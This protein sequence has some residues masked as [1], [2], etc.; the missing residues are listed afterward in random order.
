MV[1]EGVIVWVLGEKVV[2]DV[3]DG[4]T[5]AD[6]VDVASPGITVVDEFGVVVPPPG[7][8]VVEGFNEA[9]VNSV[10]NGVYEV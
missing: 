9:G 2:E 7:L 6:F 8:P 1:G 4:I 5:V 10:E 3:S